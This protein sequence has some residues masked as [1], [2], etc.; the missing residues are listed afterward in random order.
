MFLKR[1]AATQKIED[2]SSPSFRS[3]KDAQKVSYLAFSNGLATFVPELPSSEISS[4]TE[5]V[6]IDQDGAISKEDIETFISRHVVISLARTGTLNGYKA[7][8]PTEPLTEEQVHSVLSTLRL[9]LDRK[10]ISNY[11]LFRKLDENEDGFLNIEEFSK[12]L[13]QIYPLPQETK[14]AFFAYIDKMHIGLIDYKSFLRVMQ[15]SVVLKDPVITSI[16]LL[17]L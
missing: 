11:D 17:I 4:I 14:D 5:A 12:N 8:F 15:K 6:D 2:V 7:S 16:T 13:D 9:S 1:I 10:R 3:K